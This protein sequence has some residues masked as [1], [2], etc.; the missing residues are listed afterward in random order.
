MRSVIVSVRVG[1]K[2]LRSFSLPTLWS[3]RQRRKQG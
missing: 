1:P 3:Q 2:T